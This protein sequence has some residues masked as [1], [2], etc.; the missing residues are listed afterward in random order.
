MQPGMGGMQASCASAGAPGGGATHL[1]AIEL[2]SGVVTVQSSPADLPLQAS[3]ASGGGGGGGG[4]QTRAGAPA[5]APG[6]GATHLP[7]SVRPSALKLQSSPADFP[8]QA[9]IAA[10]GGGPGGGRRGPASAVSSAVSALLVVLAPASVQATKVVQSKSDPSFV[11]M[12]P[13]F[14]QEDS[15]RFAS[16]SGAAAAVGIPAVARPGAEIPAHPAAAVHRE[17]I[18]AAD[19]PL[20]RRASSAARV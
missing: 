14:R 19:A 11:S 20:P 16:V 15:R 7:S 3:M 12:C 1:P 2:P 9:S 6:G 13:P 5:G 10:C 18:P 4:A 8:L 17:R